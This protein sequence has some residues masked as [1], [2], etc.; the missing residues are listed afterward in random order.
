[1]ARIKVILQLY[2]SGMEVIA[3]MVDPNALPK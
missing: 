3:A 2:V 1:M